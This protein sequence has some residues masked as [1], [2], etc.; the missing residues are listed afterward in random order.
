[1]PLSSAQYQTLLL[2]EIGDD[3]TVA[4]I[5]QLLWAKHDDKPAVLQYVYA[6]IDA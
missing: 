3:G 6:K 2:A 4:A 5:V 1:M